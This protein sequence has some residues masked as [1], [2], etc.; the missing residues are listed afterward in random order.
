MVAALY[1]VFLE[2]QTLV[3]RRGVGFQ[4]ER[5]TRVTVSTITLPRSEGETP[6]RPFHKVQ[7]AQLILSENEEKQLINVSCFRPSFEEEPKP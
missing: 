4:A 6:P 1:L 3:M 7:L 5:E 2:E